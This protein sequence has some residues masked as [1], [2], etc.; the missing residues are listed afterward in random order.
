MHRILHNMVTAHGG[1]LTP[2]HV[3]DAQ[4]ALV[5]AARGYD[6]AAGASFAT[7]AAYWIRAAVFDRYAKDAG[8]VVDKY[9]TRSGRRLLYGKH[10]EDHGVP[11]EEAAVLRAT[12]FGAGYVSIDDPNCPERPSSW[13]S[14]EEQVGDA[15][16]EAVRKK[17]IKRALSRLDPRLREIVKRRYLREEPQTLLEVGEH[18][19]VSRERVRQLELR[20]MSTLKRLLKGEDH[21]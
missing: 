18:M 14:P 20:A 15:E 19:G 17:A 4:V 10:E 6:P 1:R 2:D 5:R 12:K 9:T 3:G 11:E 7:Y 8:G 21:T 13:S 16:E